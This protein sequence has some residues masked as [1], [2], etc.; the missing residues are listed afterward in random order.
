MIHD[1]PG[2][3]TV[4][5][6]IYCANLGV[7]MGY[8]T[9]CS[10]V[11]DILLNINVFTTP[12]VCIV[13]K[14]S[15]FW[16]SKMP[17]CRGGFETPRSSCKVVKHPWGMTDLGTLTVAWKWLEDSELC[18]GSQLKPFGH[19]MTWNTFNAVQS[20]IRFFRHIQLLVPAALCI[21]TINMFSF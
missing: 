15:K 8:Y 19:A 5:S 7:Q 4:D 11:L 1:T 14:L 13:L 2:M 21:C 18:V 9:H 10:T 17:C 3:L 6:A 16:W 20:Q 12:F